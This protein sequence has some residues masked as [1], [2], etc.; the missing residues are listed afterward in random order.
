[1]GRPKGSRN[2]ATERTKALIAA[3]GLTPLEFLLNVL[4]DETADHAAR[5]DAAKAAA[6][7]IHPK[8]NN[9]TLAGD[10]DNPVRQINR[11]EVVYVDP[12]T[13]GG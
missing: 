12:E 2:K 3:S 7:Y 8:L 1:M 13:E 5:I 11:V 4:R 6:P 9:V 10:K